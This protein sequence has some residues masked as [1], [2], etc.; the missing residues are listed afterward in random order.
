MAIGAVLICGD[1]IPLLV[2]TQMGGYMKTSPEHKLLVAIH[3]DE[4]FGGRTIRQERPKCCGK[5]INLYE[6]PVRFQDI[7]IGKISFSLLVAQC[8]EC[9]KW[10][11]P[12]YNLMN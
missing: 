6:T 1:I 3:S 9:G 12:V 4:V 11:K 8:P 10:R 5:D 2:G 7:S